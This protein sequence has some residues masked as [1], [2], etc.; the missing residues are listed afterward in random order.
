MLGKAQ[1]AILT[2]LA[3]F[4]AGRTRAQVATLSGYSA[5]SSGLANALGAL[6]SAGLVNRGDPI[7]IT[8]QGLA[9]LGDAYEPLPSGPALVDYWMS[10]LGKA[11]RTLL[12]VFLDA[13]PEPLTK[14]L[15]AERSGYSPSS[16]GL[17]NALGRLRTLELIRGWVA[18][19]TL[20][21]ESRSTRT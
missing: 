5:K 13:W 10:R 7:R 18:D 4:P 16:S 15:V 11:E 21:R 8:Q 1:R 20:A 14:K 3:Q 2:V 9:A 6:R 12:R 19:E 17:A